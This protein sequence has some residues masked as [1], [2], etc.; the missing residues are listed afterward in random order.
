VFGELTEQVR[1]IAAEAGK[2]YRLN[3]NADECAVA[4]A[5]ATPIALFAVEVLTF[6][7]FSPEK[8]TAPRDVKLTFSADGP[9]HLMLT[10]HDNALACLELRTGVPS[11][12]RFL[13]AFADQLQ[14]RFRVEEDAASGCT[15]SLRIPLQC[16]GAIQKTGIDEDDDDDDDDEDDGPPVFRFR[17]QV[18]A[19]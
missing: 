14:A 1:A 10:I 7:L 13:S 18:K 11:P 16:S 2:L 8:N 15:I 9:E 19:L 4:A 6:S 5:A 3:V 17:E 12:Q